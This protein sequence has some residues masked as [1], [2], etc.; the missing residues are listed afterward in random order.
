[1]AVMSLYT[2][3]GFHPSLTDWRNHS[4]FWEGRVEHVELGYELSGRCFGASRSIACTRWCRTVVSC[5]SGRASRGISAGAGQAEVDSGAHPVKFRYDVM[6]SEV[7]TWGIGG[8]ARIYAEVSTPDELATVLRYCTCHNVR[9]FVVGKGSNCLFDDRG[10]DG[11]VI[12]NRINFLEKLGTGRYRVGSGYAFNTL[13]VQCSRDGFSGLEF[14]GGIPGTVGGAI[15]MNAGADGQETG[16]VVQ[17]VE[18]LTTSGVSHSLSRDAGELKFDYR[19][20]P[21]QK[22]SD[23][24]VIV[25][26]T[27]DLQPNS[28][29]KQRQR[30]YL[31]RRKRTQPVTEKSAGCVFRNPGAGCQSAGALIEQAGLK[32][33]AIGGA[34]VSE[35]HANFLIN[36]GGSK[37]QDVQAL[38]ALVKEEV[39]KK[40]GL[41]LQD[42]VLYIPYNQ[43]QQL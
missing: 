16:D 42:E 21:F 38:I 37:S 17:N 9:W 28:D 25:A 33:V 32:G 31:E 6:L 11:C 23:F 29:A 13:G 26:A 36:G 20:S 5:D 39:H 43:E 3:R 34:R 22:M 30:I 12:L 14:A 8:P 27:F 7:S 35:K 15:Y 18:I 41:W 19:F 4:R 1:M 10:F 40:F 2:S 24:S